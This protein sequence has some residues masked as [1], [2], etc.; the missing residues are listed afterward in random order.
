ML[1]HLEV[2]E[3]TSK[4]TDEKRLALRRTAVL[5]PEGSEPAF[6][7]SKRLTLATRCICFALS[8]FNPTSRNRLPESKL[9]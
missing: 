6:D 8:V 7:I 4:A 9:P 1:L 5:T 2:K 3:K